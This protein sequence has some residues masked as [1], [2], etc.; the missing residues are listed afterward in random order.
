MID[1]FK[2]QITDSKKIDNLLTKSIEYTELFG[3]KIDQSN[4]LGRQTD[5]CVKYNDCSESIDIVYKIVAGKK[6]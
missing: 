4:R 3:K 6:G 1:F 2:H 5:N